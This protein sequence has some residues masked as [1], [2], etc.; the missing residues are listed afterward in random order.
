MGLAVKV[1]TEVQTDQLGRPDMGIAVKGLLA[2]HIELKAPGKGADPEKFKGADKEQWERFKNLPN[3]IYTD[4]NEW[5]LYRSGQ[6]EGK[7]VRLA[8]D[9]TTAGQAAISPADAEAILTL[10][11]D[12]LRWEPIVPPSPTALAKM[13][14]PL[15]RLLRT[16]VLTALQNRDSNLSHLATDWRKYLFPDAD[17]FQFADA[18]AQTLPMHCPGPPS[19]GGGFHPRPTAI[20]TGYRLWRTP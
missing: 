2:G 6:L 10:M 16:D 20:R 17:D 13:L 19:A 9:V 12:F 8:G 3:L 11:Q 14:A 7:M 18:Y 1:V 15:C 5:A 4:G